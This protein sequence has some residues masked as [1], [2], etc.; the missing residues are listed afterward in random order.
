MSKE[1]NTIDMLIQHEAALKQ[2]YE[3]FRD[4]FPENKV[5][6]QVIADE[7]QKHCD[8]LKGLSLRASLKGWFLN[9]RQFQQLAIESAVQ[10]V[11]QKIDAA[12]Q[13][14]INLLEALSIAGDFE[15][16]LIEKQFI[17]LNISGPEE[18]KDAMRMLVADT[19][20]HRKIIND[21]RNFIKLG[22]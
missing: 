1:P 18:V 14:K 4:V 10:Y 13:A 17:R 12:R 7:E 5:F 20:R 6:W 9:D 2:L 15:E 16:A 22:K 3:V 8:I 19:Q 11:E 21:K